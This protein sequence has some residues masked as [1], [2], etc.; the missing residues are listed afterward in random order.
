[1]RL[2]C[3]L[4]ATVMAV[5][6][7][8]ASSAHAADPTP[9]WTIDDAERLEPVVVTRDR[10]H[11]RRRK[12]G[13][14]RRPRRRLRPRVGGQRVE[15]P[16]L[17]GTRAD[18][19]TDADRDRQLA[20]SRRSQPRRQEGSHR[21]CRFHVPGE[22]ERWRHR[23]PQRRLRAVPLLDARHVQRRDRRTR[24]RRL[25]RRRLLHSRDRRRQRRRLP[26]I[27][28]GSWDHYVHAIDHNCHELSGFPYLRRRH[29]LVVARALRRRPR[30]THGDLHRERPD[31]RWSRQ[32]A[33]RRAPRPRLAERCRARAV[34]APGQRRHPVEPRR[35]ATSTATAAPTSSSARA[36]RSTASTVIACGRS[37]PRPAP[38]SPAGR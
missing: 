1:M 3:L 24:R 20:R 4:V 35:S 6:V 33:G 27:V 37:T 26:D 14:H 17:A 2:R 16:R 31:R 18:G 25:L 34:E 36:T 30:R 9:N 28:F 22:P 13:D 12:A 8:P 21:R 38:T 10:R 29:D 32:L 5:C 19:R 15:P 7:I 23:L 11:Q